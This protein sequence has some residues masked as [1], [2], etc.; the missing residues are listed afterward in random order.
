MYILHIDP[1]KLLK[2]LFKIAK[3]HVYFIDA[4]L[5]IFFFSFP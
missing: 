3:L 1:L 4:P 2:T 5:K